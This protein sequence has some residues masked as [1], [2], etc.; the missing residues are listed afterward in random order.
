MH[1]FLCSA[2]SAFFLNNPSPRLLLSAEVL[3]LGAR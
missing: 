3:A 1:R 2:Y